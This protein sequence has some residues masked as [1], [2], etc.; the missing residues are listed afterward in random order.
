VTSGDC[1]QVLLPKWYYN[2]ETTPT[3]K[4]Y[5]MLLMDGGILFLLST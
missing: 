3:L 1:C 2:I 4:D 5:C